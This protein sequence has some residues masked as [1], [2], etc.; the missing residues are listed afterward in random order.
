M[1]SFEHFLTLTLFLF[2][3][4]IYKTSFFSSFLGLPLGWDGK[5]IP[6]WLYRLHGLSKSYKCEI[7]GNHT[8]WGRKEFD[9]HFQEQR[10]IHGMKCLKIPNTTHFHGIIGISDA[11]SLYSKL[12]VTI[13]SNVWNGADNEEF[14]DSA[15]N[16]MNK[17][18][19]EDLKKQG[20][21]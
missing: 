14:E 11:L 6:Y 21:L 1:N 2:I 12:K 7:C 16:I 19:Y 17:A 4:L 3:T 8:Y 15:G 9:S 18:S 5:P 20:L 13:Q 10:H